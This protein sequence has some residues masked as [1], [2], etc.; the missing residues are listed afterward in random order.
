MFHQ[1][2]KGKQQVQ[3]K[4]NVIRIHFYVVDFNKLA[5]VNTYLPKQKKS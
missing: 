3:L 1:I 5:Y 4:C 2:G